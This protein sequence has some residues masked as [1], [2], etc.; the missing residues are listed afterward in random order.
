[1]CYYT[2]CCSM[3]TFQFGHLLSWN[4]I[5]QQRTHH[6]FI[7]VSICVPLFLHSLGS[8]TQGLC[9]DLYSQTILILCVLEQGLAE[10]VSCPGCARMWI[11][12]ASSGVAVCT[13]NCAAASSLFLLF[14]DVR[15]FS[16]CSHYVAGSQIWSVSDHSSWLLGPFGTT[17]FFKWR[18]HIVTPVMQGKG[19]SAFPCAS[20]FFQCVCRC[21]QP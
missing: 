14:A 18:W 13:T 10:S 9:T 19:A 6:S 4:Y 20:R 3:L 16:V 15:Y 7:C 11:P 5:V 1:M 8:W 12:W 21:T 2:G 17:L